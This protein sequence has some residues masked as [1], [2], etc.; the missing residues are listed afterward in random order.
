[1]N[2]L[3]IQGKLCVV[4]YRYQSRPVVLII[5]DKRFKTLVNILVYNFCLAVCLR[6][7][8]NR[9]LYLNA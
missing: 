5:I 2:A 3:V 8:R 1:L 7:K 9:E 4:Y 6:I